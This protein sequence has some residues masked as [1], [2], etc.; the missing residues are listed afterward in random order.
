MSECER[1]QAH[2][3]LKMFSG[4]WA[5]EGGEIDVLRR[6]LA[7]LHTEITDQKKR[8]ED[9]AFKATAMPFIRL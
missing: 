9:L 6:D 4:C 1:A 7:E 8:D 3:G 2:R 5:L